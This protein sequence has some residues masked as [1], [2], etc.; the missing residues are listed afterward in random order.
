M[1]QE[2][3]GRGNPILSNAIVTVAYVSGVT[4]GPDGGTV[5]TFSNLKTGVPVLITLHAGNRSENFGTDNERWKGTVT[6][7]DFILDRP[8]AR[9]II[10]QHDNI[11]RMVGWT[12]RV[13]SS[14]SH[15]AAPDDMIPPLV[16]CSC[17]KLEMPADFSTSSVA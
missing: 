12:L 8:D 10:T 15:P 4:Q 9:L 11:A 17:T 5:E 3:F 13:V 16:R 2:I 7:T 1:G 14:Q 6:G